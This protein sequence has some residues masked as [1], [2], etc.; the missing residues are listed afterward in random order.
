MT[1]S[2][3][4][5]IDNFQILKEIKS[6]KEAQTFLVNLEGEDYLLKVYK[7]NQNYS[8]NLYQPY[9][10]EAR[11]NKFYRKMV[12]SKSFRG[13]QY[14]S[15][16]RTLRE[17]K[18]IERN[19]KTIENLDLLKS[20]N[21]TLNSEEIK[22]SLKKFTNL[23]EFIN[24]KIA[25][26]PKPIKAY[27]NAILMEFIGENRI[28]APRLADIRLA[29]NEKKI[30]LESVLNTVIIL[31]KNGVI[32]SDLSPFN[33]LYHQNQSYIIDFPQVVDTKTNP[34]WKDFLDKDLENLANYFDIPKTEILAYLSNYIDINN[35]NLL[36]KDM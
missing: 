31:F 18:A 4:Q 8:Y 11:I 7:D 16:L 32:H 33:I 27:E 12:M 35:Q 20:G 15:K 28:P 9:L 36:D 26:I 1:I 5:K 14:M 13:K 30:A 19:Y 23:K 25:K 6:G 22:I 10:A 29:E 17:F 3:V 2:E 24:K 34:N 21:L